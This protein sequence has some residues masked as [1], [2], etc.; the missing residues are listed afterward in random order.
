MKGIKVV[1]KI[2]ICKLYSVHVLCFVLNLPKEAT[3]L[4]RIGPKFQCG[5]KLEVFTISTDLRAWFCSFLETNELRILQENVLS[6]H[7]GQS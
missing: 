5:S 2:S 3:D 6:F 4:A 1:K 7:E